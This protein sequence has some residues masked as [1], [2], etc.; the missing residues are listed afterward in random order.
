MA[1]LTWRKSTRNVNA[2]N[3]VEVGQRLPCTLVN[4]RDTAEATHPY[5]I[6]LTVSPAVWCEFNDWLRSQPEVLKR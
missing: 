5:R 1:E 2:L 3:C 4:V 6:T